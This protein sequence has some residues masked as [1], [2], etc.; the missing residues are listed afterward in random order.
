M[1]GKA[2]HIAHSVLSCVALKQMLMKNTQL[3]ITIV[4]KNPIA[5]VA[6]LS[7]VTIIYAIRTASYVLNSGVTEPNLTRIS[8]EVEN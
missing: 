3:L 1:R 5:N 8:H 7:I 6:E 4:L 2:Q